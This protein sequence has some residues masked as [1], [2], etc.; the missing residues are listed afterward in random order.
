MADRV[1]YSVSDSKLGLLDLPDVT[2]GEGIAVLIDCA[3]VIMEVVMTGE[4]PKGL[5]D[6]RYDVATEVLGSAIRVLQAVGF[7]EREIPKLFQQ[8][9]DRRIRAPLWLEQ[10]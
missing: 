6:Q 5:R 8:V 9:A 2:F 7:S 10:V 1:S 3:T 4:S